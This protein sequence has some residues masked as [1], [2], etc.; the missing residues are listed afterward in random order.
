MNSFLDFCE[1]IVDKASSGNNS[2][3]WK[4]IFVDFYENMI[5]P[6]AE[7]FNYEIPDKLKEY[8]SIIHDNDILTSEN[9]I[10]SET[11]TD[12]SEDNSISQ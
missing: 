3:L 10:K 11:N 2:D 9:S 1:Y 12:N 7:E 5:K 8:I 4:F 6:Y